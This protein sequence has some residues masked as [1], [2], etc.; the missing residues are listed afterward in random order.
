MKIEVEVYDIPKDKNRYEEVFDSLPVLLIDSGQE[1]EHF[2]LDE[3]NW[4]E[5]AF[6]MTY[7]DYEHYLKLSEIRL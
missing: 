3:N 5:C 2:V 1:R 7:E 6:Y 4:Y